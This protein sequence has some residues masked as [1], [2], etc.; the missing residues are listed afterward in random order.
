[1]LKSLLPIYL[2]A[3]F[4]F[5]AFSNKAQC[6][7][8]PVPNDGC[9]NQVIIDDDFC[10]DVSW[11]GLCQAAYDDC[12]A[13]GGGGAPCDN[14]LNIIGCG[15]GVST[16]MS[17]TGNW[18]L[19]GCWFGGTPGVESL[20]TFTPTTSGVHSI[21]IT[22]A[23]GG[24]VDF[25][26]K[27]VSDGCTPTGWT[28][29]DDI[30][31][32]GN[33]GSMT[34]TAG[35]QYYILLDPEG[36]GAYNF[37]FDLNCPN[38]GGPVVAGDCGSA[39]SICTNVNFSIDPNGYGLVD[40]ICTFCP[41][42][43]NLNPASANSGCLLSG[44]LNSTWFLVNVAAGGTLEF[45]FGAAGGGNCYDWT[46]WPY[47]PTTCADIIAGTQAPIRCNYNFPCDSYTGVG[48]PPPAGGAAGNFEPTMNV[49][50]GDQ[51]L[52]CF[53]NYSS[54]ATNVPLDFGGTSD[55]SCTPLYVEISDFYGVEREGYNELNWKTSAEYNNSHFEVER[56]IDGEN[57][58][59]IGT[60][61]G[62]G[63]SLEEST[64]RFNDYS[65]GNSATYYRLKQFDYN[66]EMDLSDIIV[67]A[68]T[69]N[70]EF[71]VVNAFP[72]PTSD[73]FTIQLISPE[74]DIVSVQVRSANG[75]TMSTL[76]RQ[77]QTGINELE[78]DVSDLS[79]G[80][81]MIN[82][83]N[84]KSQKTEVIKLNIQ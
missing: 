26:F 56:S 25:F 62:N 51:F 63:N 36:T 37:T 81:Y 5:I 78:L 11:D 84:G 44:E 72:N 67:M 33:Y 60:V 64:Y 57:F 59:S 48:T 4:M 34:M 15:T 8:A 53:S 7:F 18:N 69:G 52:I 22:S 2:T 76:N 42:N 46:M 9:Y 1:M 19:T 16:S 10:C 77:L 23:T 40:E 30:S 47:G 28:C 74:E 68:Q 71:K 39:E 58:T 83:I 73:F 38:P 29:I 75:R 79:K 43:P 6:V 12:I 49:L 61:T 70:R 82:I 50:T 31:I 17:G 80:L 54:A 13:L 3:M 66:G 41:S 55:I 65:P 20:F 27:P 24:F 14:I 32:P 35:V 21:D 45:S